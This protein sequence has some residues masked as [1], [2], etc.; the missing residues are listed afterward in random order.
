MWLDTRKK[1][2]KKKHR[3][4][5]IQL[6]LAIKDK[7]E[8]EQRKLYLLQNTEKKIKK[9]P[10]YAHCVQIK[11][12]AKPQPSHIQYK[13]ARMHDKAGYSSKKRIKNLDFATF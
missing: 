5:I 7:D 1:R 10:R 2:G 12:P 9:K 11:K 13:N 4:C 6:T 3:T 8:S